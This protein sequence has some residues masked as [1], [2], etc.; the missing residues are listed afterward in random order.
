MRPW[1]RQSRGAYL[2]TPAEADAQVA[3]ALD[4]RVR[5][6]PGLILSEDGS[7]TTTHGRPMWIQF[8][9]FTQFA[10]LGAWDQTPFLEQI[11]SHQFALIVLTFDVSTDVL[12]YRNIVTAEMLDAIRANYMLDKQMWFYYVYVPRPR[13]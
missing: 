2:W 6:T 7:F 9:D 4:E 5:E 3:H 11:R 13:P 12:S 8:Y 10:K 1:A